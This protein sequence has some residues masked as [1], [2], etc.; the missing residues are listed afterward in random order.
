MNQRG[1]FHYRDNGILDRT[2]VRFVTRK[3][4]VQMLTELGFRIDN[5]D[6]VNIE[7][8]ASEFGFD[9]M[10]ALP[11]ELFKVL[12]DHED[13]HI[14][15]FIL[16]VSPGD[17]SNNGQYAID[18]EI[19]WSKGIIGNYEQRLAMASLELEKTKQKWENEKQNL[20]NV[21][22]ELQTDLDNHRVELDKKRQQVASL[23]GEL[24]TALNKTH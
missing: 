10:K 8:D 2:H 14:Y 20:Q 7:Y 17:T 11:A 16:E 6:T 21:I 4:L 3:S 18:K 1:D 24:E 19:D 13:A 15:Q 5:F 9:I 23:R 12:L 22:K